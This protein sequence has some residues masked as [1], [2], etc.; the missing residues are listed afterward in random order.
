MKSSYFICVR[1][2]D[3]GALS[4]EKAFMITVANVNEAATE[5]QLS[6]GRVMINSSAGT[7]VGVLTANDPDMGDVLT[8]DLTPGYADNNQFIVADP[9][10][11][12]NQPVT[13]IKGETYSIEVQV[14]DAGGLGVNQTFTVLVI[15]EY[16]IYLPAVVR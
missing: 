7:A 14:R 2:T 11:T 15:G 16:F 4:F 13:K 8:F 1:S 6:A 10:L 12:L 9:V 3:Q 5:I